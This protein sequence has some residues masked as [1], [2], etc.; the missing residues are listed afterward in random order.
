MYFSRSPS[1][2][3]RNAQGGSYHVPSVQQPLHHLSP[4][5]PNNYPAGIPRYPAYD[6]HAAASSNGS[7]RYPAAMPSQNTSKKPRLIESDHHISQDPYA[8]PPRGSYGLSRPIPLEAISPPTADE[9]LETETKL[10]HL[11][12]DISILDRRREDSERTLNQW[13]AELKSVEARKVRLCGNYR[14]DHIALLI[15]S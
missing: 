13:E 9:N 11:R 1:A 3:H 15:R 5:V 8:V 2:T 7:D 14:F 6:Y 10:R 4:N 12:D